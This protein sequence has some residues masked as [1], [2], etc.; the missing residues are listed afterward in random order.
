[1]GPEFIDLIK[2]HKQMFDARI[3]KFNS[4]TKHEI[5]NHQIWRSVHDCERNAISTFAY[6]L[7]GPKQIMNKD[8]SQMIKMLEEKNISWVTDVPR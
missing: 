3:L 2:S 8:C 7:F 4:D 5:L 6:T 1:L